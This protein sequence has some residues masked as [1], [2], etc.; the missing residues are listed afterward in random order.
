MQHTIDTKYVEILQQLTQEQKQ[1]IFMHEWRLWMLLKQKN[2][3]LQNI[4]KADMQKIG[5][6][7][8]ELLEQLTEEVYQQTGTGNFL[9][10]INLCFMGECTGCNEGWPITPPYIQNDGTIKKEEYI[11][12]CNNK[13][14]K[15]QYDI[16]FCD[17]RCK[18]KPEIRFDQ[19]TQQWQ[20]Q[21]DNQWKSI[22][23]A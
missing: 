18:H 10:G 1:V 17:L 21:E 13:M 3:F 23:D 19:E 16:I 15:K 12:I 11:K 9:L 4:Y 14:T 5:V 7:E 6:Y 22:L 8:L 2:L 20:Y